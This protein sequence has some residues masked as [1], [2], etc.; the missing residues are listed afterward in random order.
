M[1]TIRRQWSPKNPK[2]EIFFSVPELLNQL[3]KASRPA[4]EIE[5][6]D[7]A[8]IL[9]RVLCM[10]RGIDLAKA[11][12]PLKLKQGVYFLY[13]KRKG[14]TNW[15]WFPVPQL[16]PEVLDP[17][18]SVQAYI[19]A[20]PN[21]GPELFWAAPPHQPKPL[22]SDTIN[23]ITKRLLNKYGLSEYAAHST[24]GACATSLLQ[25]GVPPHIVQA[26]GDWKSESCFNQ[27][28]NRVS[29][30]QAWAQCLIPDR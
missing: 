19:Q 16:K 7:R 2:Y 13:M 22:K 1:R 14:R 6:R 18:A 8:I 11:H 17:V 25:Q 9:L 27:F 12:R 24:R 26:L 21:R 10:F 29:A 30:T 5:L 20:T 4:N 15:A 23:G 3:R 28:Y